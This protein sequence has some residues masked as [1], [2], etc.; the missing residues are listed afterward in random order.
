M[1]EVRLFGLDD[2]PLQLFPCGAIH[3]PTLQTLLIADA[4]FGKAVSFR[5]LGVPVPETS[6]VATLERLDQLVGQT[7]AK[8]IVFLGD[9]LHSAWAHAPSTQGI[10]SSWRHRNTELALTLVRGNHDD[11]AGDPPAA[12]G[13]RVVDEPLLIYPGHSCL[14]LCHHPQLI[15]G[16]YVL[17]GHWHPCVSVSGRGRDSLRL[18]CFWFGAAKSANAMGILPAFGSFTG[19]YPIARRAGDTVF[20]VAGEVI[21]EVPG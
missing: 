20:A 9:F 7:G 3:V 10:L 1:L 6:T 4:H 19:M 21:R 13:I 12:L 8:S 18:S 15:A 17:A 11:K 5:R 16:A 14:A 2:V